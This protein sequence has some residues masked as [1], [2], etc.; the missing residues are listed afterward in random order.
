MSAYNT[1]QLSIPIGNDGFTS[2][3]ELYRGHRVPVAESV[4]YFLIIR[5]YFRG[6]VAIE[7]CSALANTLFSHGK[8]R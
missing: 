1:K 2:I 5:F 7:V 6:Q 8:R 4:E 3:E